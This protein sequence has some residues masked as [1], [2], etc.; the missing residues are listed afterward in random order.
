MEERKRHALDNLKRR[1]SSGASTTSSSSASPKSRVHSHSLG[2]RNSLG[3]NESQTITLSEYQEMGKT[4]TPPPLK[5]EERDKMAE[6]VKQELMKELSHPWQQRPGVEEL[7]HPRQQRSG[8]EE[9]SH[10]WQ[11]RPRVEELPHPRQ[12]RPPGVHSEASDHLRQ[13]HH[14][15]SSSPNQDRKLSQAPSATIPTTNR[16]KSVSFHNPP[17]AVLHSMSHSDSGE[18]TEYASAPTTGTYAEQHTGSLANSGALTDV[19]EFDPIS[20]K[21]A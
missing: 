9:L 16:S 1:R 8:V 12:Q 10:P 2:S 11:T 19:S 4:P 6:R 14:S 3:S 17:S 15:P 13:A 21:K 5:N 7:S 20:H 18:W